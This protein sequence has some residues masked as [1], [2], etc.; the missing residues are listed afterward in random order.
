MECIEVPLVND[1]SLRPNTIFIRESRTPYP[2]EQ[3]SSAAD[4]EQL[5][6]RHTSKSK[7]KERHIAH[8]VNN[9][10]EKCGAGSTVR[11]SFILFTA[12]HCGGHYLHR[13]LCAGYTPAMT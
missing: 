13:D 3:S 11:V 1:L 12:R 9:H 6:H 2:G 7:A 5:A 8:F 10:A 4:G